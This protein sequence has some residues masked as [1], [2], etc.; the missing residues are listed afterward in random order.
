MDLK[1]T[2]KEVRKKILKTTFN[3]YTCHISSSLSCVEI[4]TF[5]YFK[6]MKINPKNPWDEKRDRFILSKGHAVAS[7]YSVLTQRGFFSE[8]ILQSYCKN[9]SKLPGHSTYRCAPGVETS[10]GSLGH[11]LP[12][13][14]GIALSGKMDKKEYRV[15][16]MI[17]DGECDEGSNWE[18]ALFAS[19]HKLDNLT[20]II[21]YNNL[22]A[23]GKTN[24]ILNLEPLA[25]KWE[26]FGWEVKEI[27]G[28][29]FKEIEKAFSKIP[30]K[31][32][33]PSLLIAH[34]VK[35]KGVSFMENKLEWH[36]YNLD[37]EKYQK[38]LNDIEK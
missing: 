22:Q 13:S 24:E 35:G 3:A 18:A 15:F 31:K 32:G 14:V 17:S 25:D 36:Y 2:A 29:N 30:F 21:D 1:E 23:F 33:K 27:D 4:L 5:L 6:L 7:L 12:M 11:G 19:H 16:T 38:A 37:Q 8:K 28:H 34:T 9:G 10:T 26:S 20:V